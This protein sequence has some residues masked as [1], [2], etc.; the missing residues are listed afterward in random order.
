[1]TDIHNNDEQEKG[2]LNVHASIYIRV[3]Y[4]NKPS[5]FTQC[6]RSHRIME[7]VIEGAYDHRSL[8]ARDEGFHMLLSATMTD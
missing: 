2:C 4:T 6:K 7:A 1:M 8:I 3:D 5:I